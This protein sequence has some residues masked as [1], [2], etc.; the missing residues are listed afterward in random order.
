MSASPNLDKVVLYIP[1]SI[2]VEVGLDLSD[3]NWTLV[4]LTDKVMAKPDIKIGAESSTIKMHRF[5]S[6]VLV[7]GVR[8]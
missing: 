5:N 1:C 2:D 8:E 6:D 7:I 4:D 3:Y